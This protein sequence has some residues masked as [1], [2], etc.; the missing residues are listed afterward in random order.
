[1]SLA[2]CYFWHIS[3]FDASHVNGNACFC[4]D[5]VEVIN[6]ERKK[7]RT[8]RNRLAL[9]CVYYMRTEGRHEVNINTRRTWRYKLGHK[10]VHNMP[11]TSSE[12]RKVGCPIHGKKVII[13]KKDKLKIK[14]AAKSDDRRIYLLPL[15]FLSD[16][17]STPSFSK[18]A[19]DAG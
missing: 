18:F 10:P 15:S 16:G 17:P 19:E 13:N 2:C 8:T 7:K 6:N 12:R 14:A 3:C 11:L 4:L 9:Y 1:M 5:A